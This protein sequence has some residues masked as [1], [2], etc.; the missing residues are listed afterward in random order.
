MAFVSDEILVKCGD[1]PTDDAIRKIGTRSNERLV[2]FEDL[3]ATGDLNS[4]ELG[5]TAGAIV[6]QCSR[7]SL[8]LIFRNEIVH[9]LRWAGDPSKNIAYGTHGPRLEPRSSFAEY[10]DQVR[11]RCR[12]WSRA[13]ESVAQHV[14]AALIGYALTEVDS[15]DRFNLRLKNQQDLLIAEL[16]HR[17]RNTL[18]LVQSVARQGTDTNGSIDQYVVSLEKR[19]GAL[20]Q[21]HS[22][23]GSS[24]QQWARLSDM[25]KGELGTFEDMCPKVVLMGPPLAVRADIAPIVALMFHELTSNAIRHGALSGIGQ[26]LTIEWR[27]DAVGATIQWCEKL[28]EAVA[29]PPAKRGFGLSLIERAV[30]HQCGGRAS[31]QFEKDQFRAELWLP[32]EV[33]VMLQAKENQAH[34][35]LEFTP[36]DPV[37][38]SLGAIMVLEDN[39]VL[40]MELERSLQELGPEG[41]ESFGSLEDAEASFERTTFDLALLDINLGERTTFAFAEHAVRRGTAVVFVTGYDSDFDLPEILRE[42]PR[43]TKPVGR[44]DL[45][46]AIGEAIR[47]RDQ[48]SDKT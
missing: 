24:G 43:V 38:P 21:A 27:Q 7:D 13:D 22:L 11:G 32:D 4:A 48:L 39:L 37:L 40:A 15:R 17:V 10:T 36:A 23:V 28:T 9:E 30:P 46:F 5:R 42:V 16:N 14:A 35:T 34:R 20:A 19:I 29:A 1:T 33:T 6:Q 44:S 2:T 47:L 41:V 12:E 18:A 25:L 26:S 45:R 31:V 3:A 8:L